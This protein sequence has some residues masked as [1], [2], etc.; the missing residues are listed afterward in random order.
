MR[1][2]HAANTGSR[3][4]LGVLGTDYS[5]TYLEAKGL[6]GRE[7]DE[8]IDSARRVIVGRIED[9]PSNFTDAEQRYA[10]LVKSAGDMRAAIGAIGFSL[11][12]V[13]SV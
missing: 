1:V 13:G 3:D 7:L 12:S 11:R 5:R 8:T 6:Q 10:R 4:V 2:L 9:N